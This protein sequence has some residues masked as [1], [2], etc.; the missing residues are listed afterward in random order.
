MGNRAYMVE[1]KYEDQR[2]AGSVLK[3]YLYRSPKRVAEIINERMASP[4][5]GCSGSRTAAIPPREFCERNGFAVLNR[6]CPTGAQGENDEDRGFQA[7]EG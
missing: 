1:A 2:F 6:F 3:E 7:D 5:S 4:P